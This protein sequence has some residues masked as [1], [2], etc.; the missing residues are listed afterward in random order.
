[1]LQFS[2]CWRQWNV[3]A[4]LEFSWSHTTVIGTEVLSCY[5]LV[6]LGK[7]S[8][9]IFG[10]WCHLFSYQMKVGLSSLCRASLRVRKF[11]IKMSL[12]NT[13]FIA[14]FVSK[15]CKMCAAAAWENFWLWESRP[16][17]C[18]FWWNSISVNIL[19]YILHEH[20]HRVRVW[21]IATHVRKSFVFLLNW[22]LS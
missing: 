17:V 10:K 9:S 6:Y 16:A 14:L 22:H 4:S 7:N 13:C 5:G 11:I 18:S 3:D 8:I 12:W 20:H 15:V 21:Y 1:M 19:C 2:S